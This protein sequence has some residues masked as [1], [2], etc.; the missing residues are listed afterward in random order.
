[1]TIEHLKSLQESGLFNM[2][3]FARLLLLEP[4]ALSARL[5]RGSPELSVIESEKIEAKLHDLFRSIDGRVSFPKK[6]QLI[7]KPR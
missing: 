2:S 6:Y 7:V 1:M 4:Q 3:A 5:K